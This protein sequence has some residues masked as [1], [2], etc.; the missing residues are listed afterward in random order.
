MEANITVRFWS[1]LS[2]TFLVSL[3]YLTAQDQ[4]DDPHK[5]FG[6]S[7]RMESRQGYPDHADVITHRHI[8]KDT[9][10]KCITV[11]S[12]PGQADDGA[13]CLLRYDTGEKY[14]LN[15]VESMRF[16]KD[17]VV[18]LECLGTKPAR[19]VIGLW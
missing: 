15:F 13:A 12:N 18:Y 7:M 1:M 10:A 8:A 9:H 11:E 5:G 2:L 16:P 4:E 3:V 17:G 6:P 19:C 14:R